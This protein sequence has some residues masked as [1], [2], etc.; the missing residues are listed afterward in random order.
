[1]APVTNN[2]TDLCR[3]LTHSEELAQSYFF[4]PL[5]HSS[6]TALTHPDYPVLILSATEACISKW[7]KVALI[8]AAALI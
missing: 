7:S 3:Y 4:S 1:M 5:M 2:D 8:T 6:C